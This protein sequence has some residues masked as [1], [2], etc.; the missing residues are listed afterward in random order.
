MDESH[1]PGRSV[2]YSGTVVGQ[3][4]TR[5]ARGFEHAGAKGRFFQAT[6][7]VDVVAATG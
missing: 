2:V 5:N 3:R 1:K 4:D 7:D 6:R